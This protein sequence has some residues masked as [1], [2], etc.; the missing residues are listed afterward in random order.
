MKAIAIVE[1]PDDAFD[2]GRWYLSNIYY[3][4]KKSLFDI[5]ANDMWELKPLPEPKDIGY[6]NDNYDVGFSDGW[7]ACLEQIFGDT[8]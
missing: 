8:K 6:P 5:F 4:E 1:L 3:T 2:K 7:D